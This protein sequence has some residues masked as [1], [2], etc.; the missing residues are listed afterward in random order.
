MKTPTLLVLNDM[1]VLRMNR[2]AVS[3]IRGEKRIE[4]IHAEGVSALDLFVQKS[5]RWFA[6]KLNVLTPDAWGI[7]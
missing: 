5:V 2:D 1:P 4:V 3:Q 7:A 6:D